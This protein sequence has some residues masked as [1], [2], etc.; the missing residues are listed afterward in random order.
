MSFGKR[1]V[2]D[3]STLVG[4][5]LLPRSVPRRALNAAREWYELCGSEAT[6]A[7]LETVL[8]RAK[9]DRYLDR[10]TREAY[11]ELMRRC[12]RLFAVPAAS[13]KNLPRPCRDPRDNKFLALALVCKAG[14]IVS[15]D[16]DLTS[17]TPYEGIDVISATDFLARATCGR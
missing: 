3:T 10:P 13:E 12:T 4:A 17:L 6:L 16:G 8:R 14:V 5:V 2:F 11:C 7:E 15:S 9:F 1:V